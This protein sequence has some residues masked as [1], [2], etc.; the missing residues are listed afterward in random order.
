MV[1]DRQWVNWNILL[2]TI[3][4]LVAWNYWVPL[5][6]VN[7][8][9]TR[10]LP[11]A[12]YGSDSADFHQYYRAGLSWLAGGNAYYDLRLIDG[13]YVYPPIS[14]PFFGMF[15]R[16]DF[17]IA[18]QLW[19]L[20]YFTVFA[21]AVLAVALTLKGSRRY[22][23]ISAAAMLLLTSYP[24]IIL[25]ELGQIDLLLSSL[26]ILSL[27]AQRLKHESAS[28]VLLSVG[29]L[30]KGP[31]ALLLV[32]FVLYRRNV[33]YLVRFAI[34]TIVL[35]LASLLIIPVR[36]YSYWIANILPTLSSAYALE[37]NQSI[38]GVIANAHMSQIT[39]AITI[40]GYALFAIF[41]L[42][43]GSK[44]VRGENVAFRDDAMFLLNVLIMLLFGSRSTVYPYVWTI[45]PLA[46]FIS[47]LMVQAT[48]S[49]YF[50]LVCAG[51]FLVNSVLS[52]DFLDYRT[53]PLALIG[54]MILTLGVTLACRH[55]KATL[56]ISP[57]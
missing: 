46:L 25:F 44:K 57:N 53:I 43:L 35:V 24:F 21:C 6:I 40:T 42:W 20:L 2:L 7:P 38:P 48:R 55:P 37:S 3:C 45:I 39:P 51:V 1:L 16:L 26:A 12:Q 11:F 49:K 33:K 28:A 30:L 10:N 31:P 47:S 54:N 34:A 13:G 50:A 15:A 5:A 52:P 17:R 14:L 19:T 27:V 4:L 8:F 18:S 56:N 23:F 29:A 41:T 22:V 36:V 9:S 32:Y